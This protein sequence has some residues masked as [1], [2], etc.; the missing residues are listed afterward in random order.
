MRLVS[1][2]IKKSELHIESS[3]FYRIYYDYFKVLG[4]KNNKCIIEIG[5]KLIF[6]YPRP[7][8][9]L[10]LN[11]SKALGKAYNILITNPDIFYGKGLDYVNTFGNNYD[12]WDKCSII[13]QFM[14]RIEYTIKNGDYSII[15]RYFD[16][17]DYATR[18]EYKNEYLSNQ[19]KKD[20]ALCIIWKNNIDELVKSTPNFSRLTKQQKIDKLSIVE[21]N[22]LPENKTYT[23]IFYSDISQ[24]G[25]A[26]FSTL[27][28]SCEID[29][30]DSGVIKYNIISIDK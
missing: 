17:D 6:S 8:I 24:T 12:S 25:V 23:A 2:I 7:R 10:P 4:I 13:E 28:S 20:R 16:G 9:E 30:N 11:V 18:T 29:Y 1:L 5:D 3:I 14:G 15:L 22:Y 21:K 27:S 26:R 19:H